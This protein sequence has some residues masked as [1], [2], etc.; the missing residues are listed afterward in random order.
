[1][2]PGT[3]THGPAS[4]HLGYTQLV[5]AP[6]R[7]KLRELT[8][9]SVARDAR[10]QGAAAALMHEVCAQADA[11]GLALMVLVE[12]YDGASMDELQLSAWYARMGFKTIQAA[13]VVMMVRK[14]KRQ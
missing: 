8:S 9:L 11:A 5:P 4:L 2:K 12:P 3:Y 10:G 7:G 1:M 14:A 13:P 6:V